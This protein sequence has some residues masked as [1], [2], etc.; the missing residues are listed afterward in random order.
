VAFHFLLGVEGNVLGWLSTPNPCFPPVLPLFDFTPLAG[1]HYLFAVIFGL[2]SLA[3][4]YYANPDEDITL[5][6]HSPFKKRSWGPKGGTGCT[7][8]KY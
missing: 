2:S 3:A 1:L 6:L 4:V 5:D 7:P 8:Y